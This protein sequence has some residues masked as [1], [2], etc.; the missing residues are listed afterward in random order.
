[1]PNQT[2]IDSVRNS[3]REIRHEAEDYFEHL[4]ATEAAQAERLYATPR[5]DDW[6]SVPAEYKE[7]QERLTA[8]LKVSILTIVDGCKGSPLTD[9][10]DIK[11]LRFDM[12]RMSAALRL[13]RYFQ[14]DTEVLH[15]EGVVLGVRPSYQEEGTSTIEEAKAF[16][17]GSY[18]EVVRILDLVSPQEGQKALTPPTMTGVVS[19]HRLNTGFVMMMMDKNKPELEDVY[20]CIKEVFGEFKIKA[21]RSDEIEHQDVITNRI[22]NEISTSEFLIAD[23]SGERPSV[24][25][26]IGYAHAIGKRP[27]L[28]RKKGT[29]L[30]FDLAV[31]NVPE[32]ENITDLRTKLRKRLAALTNKEITE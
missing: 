8:R 13:K 17:I 20:N 10:T 19:K 1:M 16:F 2:D 32:Y 28:Y 29:P 26:E 6:E 21:V 12:K 9:E 25:Y 22:L 18:D 7:A 11:D 5:S 4:L 15:D 24:Y 27:I 14:L 30:H 31:H 3:L 23:L